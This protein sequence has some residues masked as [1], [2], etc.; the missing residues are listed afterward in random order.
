MHRLIWFLCV[1]GAELLGQTCAQTLSPNSRSVPAATNPLF[2][3]SFTVASN[4]STCNWTSTSTV[5]WIDVQVGQTGRGGGTVGYSVDNNL[6]PVTRTGT[7]L[8][9]NAVFTVSQAAAACNI[10][11]TLQGGAGVGA[12]G[13]VRPLQV[14]TTCE[15]TAATNVDWI[16]IGPPTGQR[17]SGTINL[18]VL[19]NNSTAPRSGAVAV[20]GQS[21]TITQAGGTC[22]YSLSAVQPAIPAAGGSY[23]A[24]LVTACVWTASSNASWLSVNPPTSG[25]G[26]SAINYTVAANTTS[27]DPRTGFI[28]VGSVSPNGSANLSFSVQ[29]AGGNCNV[30]LGAASAQV[31]AAGIT[32]NFTVTTPCTFTA[33]S[34]VAWITV[35]AGPNAVTYNVATNSSVQARTGTITAGGAV[36][37]IAQ[38]GSTC[39]FAVSPETLD[40]PPAGGSGV[41]RL[42]TTSGCEWTASSDSAW[43]RITGR[44]AGGTQGELQYTVDANSA[45][46]ARTGTLTVAGRAITVRQNSGTAPRLTAGGIVHSASYQPGGVS[47]GEIV[48]IYGEELGPS[49][50]TTATLEADGLTVS[51]SLAGTR[52]LFDGV[53]APIVYTS[54]GQVS[55]IVPYAVAGKSTVSVTAEYLGARSS[56]VTLRILSAVP[57]LYSLDS[58]GSGPGAVLNQDGLLNSAANPA[59]VGQVVILYGT[60]EGLTTPLQAD[61]QL[62]PGVEPL[63]RPRQ[64]V[65]VTMGGVECPVLYAGAPPGLVA[66]A[67]QINVQLA[68]G[69]PAGESVPVVLAVGEALSPDSVTIAIRR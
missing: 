59:V 54:R 58:S 49:S 31:A 8:V 20:L 29:Q 44:I 24:Q 48:T 26:S 13:G 41:I 18:T 25:T 21:V 11:L 19:P 36:F 64:R 16:T 63:P 15:W 66:G 67:L 35:T 1:A 52:I 60:G 57:A 37:T 43:I 2:Q 68:A 30:Q 4:V 46:S 27:A 17:G 39:N 53:A 28:S 33:R 56:P 45:G 47:P 55:A 42:T 23:S 40:I 38:A 12:E 9:G 22:S 61:G 32:S 62:T 69:V 7:I 65:T 50:L 34:N 6:T 3:G 10:T 51:K 14:A 5:P